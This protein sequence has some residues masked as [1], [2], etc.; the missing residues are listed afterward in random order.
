[1]GANNAWS[2]SYMKLKP[3]DESGHREIYSVIEQ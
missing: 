1:M 2:E 3:L